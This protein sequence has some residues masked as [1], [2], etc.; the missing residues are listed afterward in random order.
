[1]ARRTD[2][3]NPTPYERASLERQARRASRQFNANAGKGIP[4]SPN[5]RRLPGAMA[6]VQSTPQAQPVVMTPDQLAHINQKFANK[7]IFAGDPSTVPFSDVTESARAFS[8]TDMRTPTQKMAARPPTPATPQDKAAVLLN[9]YRENLM[10]QPAL[11]LSGATPPKAPN[12]A[13]SFLNT[14]SYDM[15][16]GTI[17][18]LQKTREGKIALADIQER[19]QRF[20]KSITAIATQMGLGEVGRSDEG[21]QEF[22][23]RAIYGNP[24]YSPLIAGFAKEM[25]MKTMPKN[26]QRAMEKERADEQKR[27]QLEEQRRWYESQGIPFYRDPWGNEYTPAKPAVQEP[28]IEETVDRQKQA[29][30]EELAAR[31]RAWPDRKFKVDPL[32]GKVVLDEQK[33]G[34]AGNASADTFKGSDLFNS[35]V[36]TDEIKKVRNNI[37]HLEYGEVIDENGDIVEVSEIAAGDIPENATEEQIAKAKRESAAKVTEAMERRR[38]Y[39]KKWKGEVPGE[40]KKF[41]GHPPP[42]QAPAQHGSAS[43][44]ETAKNILAQN[45]EALSADNAI[46]EIPIEGR[47]NWVRVRFPDPVT[48]RFHEFIV[49][50]NI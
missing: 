49:E 17:Q 4:V 46:E 36:D 23:E 18:E 28:T 8:Q 29:A 12:D 3:L 25:F 40:V 6:N 35:L 14:P 33:P 34:Q 1:M 37:A 7:G 16:Y 20:A 45:F 47:P 19:Q 32:T 9:M 26:I 27:T 13:K 43:D 21:M 11:T 44:L 48:G 24:E 15:D 10:P 31:Q 2:N 22:Y 41:T 39:L 42:E 38:Q 30:E 5:D 50:K